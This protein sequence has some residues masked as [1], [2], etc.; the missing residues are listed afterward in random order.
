MGLMTAA[1]EADDKPIGDAGD[2]AVVKGATGPDA[3]QASNGDVEVPTVTTGITHDN[4][5]TRRLVAQIES[6][7]Q[8]AP[9][10]L[11]PAPVPDAPESDRND[12]GPLPQAPILD[13]DSRQVSFQAQLTDA[14]GDPLPGPL[15]DLA[16][17]IYT[18]GGALLEGPI[19]VLDAPIVNGIV[20]VQVPISASSLDG[21]GREMGVTVDG[22]AELSPRVKLTSVPYAYRV[23]RVASEE[24]D[25]AIAL[26]SGPPD[27]AATG[28]LDAYGEIAGGTPP[29][30]LTV[31]IDG[32][33]SLIQTFHDEG[34]ITSE[35][36]YWSRGRLR[37]FD[38]GSNG[39]DENN[40][41]VLLDATNDSGGQ[42]TL[43]DTSG[44]STLF[45]EGATGSISVEDSF[46]VVEQI[47]GAARGSFGIEAG[48]DGGRLET[49]SAAGTTAIFGSFGFPLPGGSGTFYQ[50]DGSTVGALV[51]G[52][53]TSGGLIGLY[54]STQ[55]LTIEANAEASDGA[56]YLAVSDSGDR[57]LLDAKGTNN[58]G[59]IVVYNTAGTPTARLQGN[60][61]SVGSGGGLALYNANATT[62]VRTVLLDGGLGGTTQGGGMILYDV[63]GDETVR[64]D[65]DDLGAGRIGLRN[66]AGIE[67]IALDANYGGDGRIITQELSITG[68]SDLSEQFQVES[69]SGAVQP[70]MVVSIDPDHPGRLMVSTEAYDRKA[71]GIVSGAGGIGT[72]MIMGQAGSIADGDHA[73]ALSGRVYCQATA[74]NGAIRPGDLLTTAD[75]AGYAMKVT[76]HTRATGAII[77]KAMT[78]LDSGEGLVL[79]L[80]SLH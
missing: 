80:V 56:A 64:I 9:P 55:A 69:G 16:F 10:N 22:G 27:V 30:G 35:L 24:L 38:S 47:G 60:E 15:V 63:A 44:A 75:V 78:G 70:G 17:Y 57:V 34:V 3:L 43:Y 74:A 8:P 72:G 36:G 53:D 73:V 26:G 6:V 12:S 62:N 65:G 19:N 37:L 28:I 33:N 4:R 39:V 23:D 79:V 20:D 14:A 29:G 5:E 40:I 2:T 76:D 11:S 1:V 54:S 58:G 41:T 42:M 50:A 59:E 32:N 52:D 18:S 31:R 45:M 71:A 21:S 61:E 67:V 48:A 46:N 25:D 49:Y 51:A 66:A 77:G 13:A 7:P 68:G